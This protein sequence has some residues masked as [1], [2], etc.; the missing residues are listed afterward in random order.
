MS[1][2]HLLDKMTEYDLIKELIYNIL[3]VL[4]IF[5]YHKVFI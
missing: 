4:Y 3:I 5:I 1:K 2:M